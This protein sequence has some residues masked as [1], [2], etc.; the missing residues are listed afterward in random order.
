MKKTWM[1][2]IMGLILLLFI[3]DLFAQNEA[4]QLTENNAKEYIERDPNKLN[5]PEEVPIEY[6]WGLLDASKKGSLQ[7]AKQ[8]K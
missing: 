8:E 1:V 4:G 2:P 5:N 3:N 6:I 7:Q